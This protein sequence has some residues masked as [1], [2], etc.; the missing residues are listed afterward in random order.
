[1]TRR[2]RVLTLITG[3]VLFVGG[4]VAGAARVSCQDYGG[5]CHYCDYWGDDGTY[6]GYISWGCKD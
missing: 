3:L 5:G 6:Q 1:M 2:G 4:A